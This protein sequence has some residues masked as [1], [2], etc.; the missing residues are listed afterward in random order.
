MG[1]RDRIRHSAVLQRSKI[2]PSYCMSSLLRRN[3][4]VKM[5]MRCLHYVNVFCETLLDLLSTHDTNVKPSGA[6][7][8]PGIIWIRSLYVNLPQLKSEHVLFIFQLHWLLANVQQGT[9]FPVA[10]M[11]QCQ[12]VP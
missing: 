3:K 6:L 2:V 11:R 1:P 5:H 7:Y 4:I 12:S 9:T 8:L 10:T